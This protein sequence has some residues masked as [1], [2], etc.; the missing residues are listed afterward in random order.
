MARWTTEQQAAIDA[1]GASFLVSAA[2]GSGKTSVLVERLIRLIADTETKIPVTEMAV[3][4]FT[5]D[6]AAEMKS[7]LARALAER[8]AAEPE[9]V[10]LRRQHGLL[11]SAKISTI[12]SFCFDLIRDNCQAL[13]I[14][15][16]FRILEET[17]EKLLRI[18]ALDAVLETWYADEERAQSMRYLCGLF[19]GKTDR[20][21]VEL[22]LKMYEKIISMPF[23]FEKLKVMEQSYTDCSLRT[24]YLESLTVR[25]AEAEE[26]LKAALHDAEAFGYQNLTDL[27]YEDLIQAEAVH[28][29]LTDPALSA[30]Q[31][32]ELLGKISFARMTTGGRKLPDQHLRENAVRLR[33][34]AKAVLT[35]VQSAGDTV[36]YMEEDLKAHARAMPLLRMLL[37]DFSDELWRRKCEKNAL[38][39]DDGE[40]VALALLGSY[41][42]EGEIVRTPLAVELSE[43]Y[44][45]ILL[46]EFQDTNNRQDLIFK[47][48]S[49]NGSAERN[50]DNLFMVG[51]LKQSIYRFRLANPQN[52]LDTMAASVPYSKESQGN[53]FLR[54]NRNFRSSHEVVEFVNFVFSAV[55]SPEVGEVDYGEGE[56]LVQGA[57][58]ADTP[59]NTEVVL[60]NTDEYGDQAAEQYVAERIAQMLKDG[61]PVSTDGGTCTRP[62]RPSDFCIL[63]RNNAT[64]MRYQAVLEECGIAA[65]CEEAAPYLKSREIS[66]LLNFLRVIDSPP[67]DLAL[68]SVLLSPMFCFTISELTE[69]RLLAPKKSLY[70]A[71]C[72]GLGRQLDQKQNEPLL[73]GGLLEKTQYFFDTLAVLRRDAM[74]LPLETLIR[75]IYDS[76]DYLAVMRRGKNGER[77]RANLRRLLSHARNYETNL[78][79]GISGFLRYLDRIFENKSDIERGTVVSGS[80]DVVAIKT[81]HKS[82]GLEFPFVFLAETN[83]KFNTSEKSDIFQFA[84]TIGFGFRMQDPEA[85]TR[86]K[87]LP[88]AL[89]ADHNAR[90]AR[91]EDLRL[92]YVALTR[93]KDKLFIP[94]VCS[95]AD[96][97]VSRVQS[98]ALEIA[99][100]GGVTPRLAAQAGSLG[101][102]LWMALLTAK[103]GAPL[104]AYCDTADCACGG[105]LPMEIT[106]YQPQVTGEHTEPEQEETDAQADPAAVAMLQERFAQCRAQTICTLP[107]K[108]TVSMLTK[109]DDAIDLA[110]RRPKFMEESGKLTPAEK[111]TALH[112][113]LQFAD[114]E[115]ARQDA[116]AE[117]LRLVRGGYLTQVQADSI[118]LAQLTEFF[119]SPLYARIRSAERVCRERRFLVKIA[120]LKLEDAEEYNGTEAMLSGIMDLVFEEEDG[121]VLVDYKTDAVS[122]KEAD[123]LQAR[124]SA[125]LRVYRRTLELIENKPVKETCLFAFSLGK[126]IPIETD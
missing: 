10:W 74:R 103:N 79:G 15:P 76:T 81:I 37:Q 60:V 116:S 97:T 96:S 49:H 5:N 39:F 118:S 3:V 14:T 17:E 72:L 56:A 77:R 99:A 23:G 93:A 92:L 94:L 69:L 64:A 104:R 2:A 65:Y 100:A 108:T 28:R 31:L 62:C 106:E 115:A 83:R 16:T 122:P 1:R 9:N 84:P 109:E 63:V 86:F 8:I 29:A 57:S 98:F 13:D 82:K 30:E 4:T 44:K 120:D 89:I 54:L 112:A 80:E 25:C 7:R 46:D 114:F 34:K 66:V 33:A 105:I 38:G 19:C 123:I 61:S 55:M 53:A 75:S 85:L 78:G 32:G 51:D 58:F 119:E 45:M 88:Y 70:F 41:T 59:R 24:Q 43:F 111:G 87:T 121:L 40:Q 117:L 26:I 36:L 42:E 67:N 113:F 50:G 18:A 126:I 48:L 20:R 110:L 107:A 35:A 47:L 21:L 12:N 52:F 102:W 73:S 6:A 95:E 125:Q 71:V 27:L 11:Q 90:L 101:D 22:L 91:S 68:A 124:H